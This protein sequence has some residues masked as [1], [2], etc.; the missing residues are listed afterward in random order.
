VTRWLSTASARPKTMPM[1]GSKRSKAT[2]QGLGRS[3]SS[4]GR[5]MMFSDRP[6]G[7]VSQ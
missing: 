7:G 2:A 1:K 3:S 6:E 4:A 5:S